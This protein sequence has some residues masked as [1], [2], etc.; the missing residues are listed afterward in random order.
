MPTVEPH[1][2]RARRSVRPIPR[3]PSLVSRPRLGSDRDD[4]VGMTAAVAAAVSA[5][6]HA[7]SGPRTAAAIADGS[8]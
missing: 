7:M 1:A 5:H 2:A 6:S 4:I 8:R 3:R